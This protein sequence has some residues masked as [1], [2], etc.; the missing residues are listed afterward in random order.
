MRLKANVYKAEGASGS[1][2]FVA[3]G[4]LG[5]ARN[6]GALAKR[7]AKRRPVVAVDLR[8]HG[9]S[10]WSA[11][12][13]YPAMADDLAETIAAETGGRAD[14]LGHSMGGKAAMALALT[15]PERVGRLI[16]ADIA[17]VAYGHSHDAI[18]A[19][20]ASLDLTRVA[21]RS[22]ADA[23]LAGAIPDPAMRAFMLT[24]LDVTAQG[25]RWRPNIER[26]AMAM[27]DILR[28]PDAWPKVPFESPTLFVRGGRSDYVTEAS[29]PAIMRLFPAA[30]FE[31]IPD[32]GHWLHADRP[33]AFVA[34]VERFLG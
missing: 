1:P 23:A 8:N 6:W 11:V 27:P 7:M 21:R 19:A 9:D 17:P 30:R 3:H 20:M 5:A 24:N 12:M 16:V 4:L 15:A 29:R 33:E 31:M 25:A 22:D 32:A 10:P 18:L 34:T 2:L 28:W 13:D 26:L 14:V